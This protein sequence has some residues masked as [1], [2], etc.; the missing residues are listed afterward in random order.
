MIKKR[1]LPK[2]W[3]AR[4]PRYWEKRVPKGYPKS[5][6]EFSLPEVYEEKVAIEEMEAKIGTEESIVSPEAVPEHE[7]VGNYLGSYFVELDMPVDEEVIELV[8]EPVEE[9]VTTTEEP[10]ADPAVNTED[11]VADPTNTETTD[12]ASTEEPVATEEPSEEPAEESDEEVF[13]TLLSPVKVKK[14]DVTGAVAFRYNDSEESWDAIENVEVVDG[15]VYGTLEESGVVATFTLRKDSYLDKSGSMFANDVY[16][17]NGISNRIY[18][19]EEEKI[20]AETSYGTKTELT[21][22]TIIVGGSYDGSSVESTEVIIEGVK[23]GKIIAGSHYDLDDEHKNFT[24]SIRLWAKDVETS[25]TITGAGTWNCADDIDIYLENCSSLQWEETHKDYGGVGCQHTNRSGKAANK[26][27][28]DSEKGLLA[29][30]WVKHSKTVL[31]NCKIDVVYAGGYNG[32]CYTKD[33]ELYVDGG[34]YMY[35][36]NGQSNGTID[37]S[38]TEVKNAHIQYLNNNNRGHY[39]DGKIVIE[40]CVIDEGYCFADPTDRQTAD[41]RGKVSIDM[42]A[43]TT[44]ANW[45]VG[46]VDSA[47][48]TTAIEAAKYI[49]RFAI[50]RDT[51]IIYTRNA[52]KILAD[53]VVVK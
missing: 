38:Y 6:S 9:T 39:G 14:A 32:Y 4:I 31:K 52:D 19:D 36:C 45:C 33:A 8:E 30:Q 20:I 49:E 13:V 22:D 41:I 17:C 26:T 42:D 50:S 24:K 25:Y 34:D 40:N 35:F 29:N 11:P 7:A 18:K 23:I 44:V 15:Y 48:V 53:I 28:A 37:N 16:V 51:A 46:S 10:A 2:I 5:S 43:D 21:E 3:L 1:L 27:M 47:E 12:P